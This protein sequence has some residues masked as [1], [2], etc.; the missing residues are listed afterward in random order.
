MRRFGASEAKIAAVQE[1]IELKRAARSTQGDVCE[2][3]TCNWPVL[4][5][6]LSLTTQ[7]M[8]AGLDGQIIGLHYGNVLAWIDHH[9]PRRK[10]R[11]IFEGIQIMERA[12]LDALEELPKKPRKQK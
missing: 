12:A 11:D 4:E 7:W 8:R 3:W 10:R 1:S 5:A 6:F 9:Y 2:V